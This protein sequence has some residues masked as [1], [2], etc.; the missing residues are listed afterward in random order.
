[1]S[2]VG[3]ESTLI[4]PTISFIS[5][6]FDGK[7]KILT[8]VTSRGGQIAFSLINQNIIYAVGVSK[9]IVINT[10]YSKMLQLLKSFIMECHKF[11]RTRYK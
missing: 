1:M 4:F 11:E 9:S 3:I 2:Y 10:C 6:I 8:I 5:Y 7:N